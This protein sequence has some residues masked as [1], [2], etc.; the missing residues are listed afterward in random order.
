MVNLL[1]GT[2]ELGR[3]EEATRVLLHRALG[4]SRERVNLG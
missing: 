1:D 2:E 4:A 3:T